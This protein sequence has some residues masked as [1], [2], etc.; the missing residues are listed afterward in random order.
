MNITVQMYQNSLIIYVQY[1]FL[2][3]YNKT[4]DLLDVS[5]N[6]QGEILS[7]LIN[8]VVITGVVNTN[9]WQ[10]ILTITHTTF[11]CVR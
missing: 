4:V 9:Q 6:N 11:N 10:D 3:S 5:Y 8:S 1:L 7:S 2:M